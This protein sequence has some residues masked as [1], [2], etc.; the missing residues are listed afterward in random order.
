MSLPPTVIQNNNKTTEVT[1][2]NVE[3][4]YKIEG[5]S[6]NQSASTGTKISI[7]AKKSASF[8]L[9]IELPIPANK[10]NISFEPL[11]ISE[12]KVQSS[13]KG[14]ISGDASTIKIS[15]PWSAASKERAICINSDKKKWKLD[16]CKK[17]K[18]T[19][20]DNKTSIDPSSSD[21]GENKK[22]RSYNCKKP[23]Q[24]YCSRVTKD[25]N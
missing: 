9:T 5:N 12:I 21:L 2:T 24:P 3:T 20:L 14:K 11:G 13:M 16:K 19:I 15:P 10:K 6:T 4:S 18:K 7:P 1:V 25:S 8:G 17:I 22:N 23:I